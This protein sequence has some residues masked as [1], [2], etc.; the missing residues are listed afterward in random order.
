MGDSFA[1]QELDNSFVSSQSSIHDDNEIDKI[2]NQVELPDKEEATPSFV[3]SQPTDADAKLITERYSE[4]ELPKVKKIDPPVIDVFAPSKKLKLN[5]KQ[6]QIHMTKKLANSTT[7]TTK[8]QLLKKLPH[9]QFPTTQTSKS[10]LTNKRLC[11]EHTQ[12]VTKTKQLKL[13]WFLITNFHSF[14]WV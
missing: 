4:D 10:I 8:M 6:N 2:E 14:A 9:S 12:K 1:M 13:V 3:S 7:K 11:S 5:L